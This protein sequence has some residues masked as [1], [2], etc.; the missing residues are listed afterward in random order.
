MSPDGKKL[1]AEDA[2]IQIP[3]YTDEELEQMAEEEYG[4]TAIVVNK[5]I[6]KGKFEVTVT[7]AGF[8][9]PYEWGERKEYLRVDLEVKNVGSE[10]DYF[11]PSGMAILD[12]QGSQYESTFGGTLDLFS[13]IYPGVTKKGYTLFGNVPKTLSTI[14]LVFELGYDKDYKPYLFKYDIQ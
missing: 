3:T 5:K 14:K 8:F 10:S 1:R 6:S 12:N 9:S 13:Q 11:S 4:K 2:T 7:K